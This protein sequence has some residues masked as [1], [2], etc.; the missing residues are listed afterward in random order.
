MARINA[1][2]LEDHYSGSR[3]TVGYLARYGIP[4]SRDGVRNLMRCMGL[5][6]IYQKPCTTII[7]AM[8][9][10]HLPGGSQHGVF[11]GPR[12]DH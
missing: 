6:A 12:L 1:L 7:G 11:S 3:R 2:N 8:R 9:M 10:V 5:R 4:I